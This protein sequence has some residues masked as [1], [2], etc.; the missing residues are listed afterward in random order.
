MLGLLLISNLQ[1]AQTPA[2][3]ELQL[4]FVDS[5]GTQRA[6]TG[7]NEF[8]ATVLFF[9]LPD[10]PVARQYSTEIERIRKEYISRGIQ[11]FT[12]IADPDYSPRKAKSFAQDYGINAPILLTS[13][14][15]IVF[16]KGQA[17]SPM[18]LVITDKSRVVYE[19]RIDDRYPKLGVQRKPQRRDLRIALEQFLTSKP[20]TVPKTKAIGCI[21]PPEFLKGPNAR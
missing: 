5:N 1:I 15:R 11:T 6:I 18:A 20:I 10:C 2:P 16:S 7:T 9:V 12:V 21:I 4:R 13:Q 14:N 3:P 19:G 17:I 8:K